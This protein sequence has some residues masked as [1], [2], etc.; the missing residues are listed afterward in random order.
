[1]F[2]Y[3]IHYPSLQVLVKEYEY[4]FIRICESQTVDRSC[5]YRTMKYDM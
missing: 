4:G 2:S 3:A 5:K 1:M